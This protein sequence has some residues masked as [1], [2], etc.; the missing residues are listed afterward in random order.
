MPVSAGCLRK[1]S[2][3]ISPYGSLTMPGTS[4]Y[5]ES[6]RDHQLS[7]LPFNHPLCPLMAGKGIGLTERLSNLLQATQQVG[8]G[9]RM[10]SWKCSSRIG[11]LNLST[12]D[13]WGLA[14]LCCRGC[15]V[16]CSISLPHLMPVHPQLW[17]IIKNVCKHC[18]R[19]LDGSKS[20]PFLVKPIAP[21]H[22]IPLTN[23]S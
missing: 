3:P 21:N 14:V 16:H 12:F 2:C 8:G 5:L 20:T 7:K 13:I 19:S 23:L 22:D 18:Q 9:A 17:L 15:P 6:R 10:Q 4:S 11:F 1:A